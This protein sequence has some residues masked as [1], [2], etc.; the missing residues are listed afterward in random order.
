MIIELSQKERSLYSNKVDITYFSVPV[1]S[2]QTPIF[3]RIQVEDG[4]STGRIN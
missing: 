2:S 3:E 1:L 4:Y